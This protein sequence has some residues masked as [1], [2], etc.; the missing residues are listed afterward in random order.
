MPSSAQRR[1][2][3]RA[4]AGAKAQ[5][6]EED[7]SLASLAQQVGGGFS[8]FMRGANAGGRP[9][10]STQCRSAPHPRAQWQ[11][12]AH[13]TFRGTDGQHHTTITVQQPQT[14]NDSDHDHNHNETYRSTDALADDEA[15]DDDVFEDDD[16]D[17]ID[18][19][20]DGAADDAALRLRVAPE[21]ANAAGSSNDS[22]S[23]STYDNAD[24]VAAFRVTHGSYADA[25]PLQEDV[26]D[27]RAATD[28]CEPSG[29]AITSVY[30]KSNGDNGEVGRSAAANIEDHQDDM[31]ASD[32]SSG[33]TPAETNDNGSP[34]F[35]K[36]GDDSSACK[37]EALMDDGFFRASELAETVEEPEDI[38]DKCTTHEHFLSNDSAQA[39]RFETVSGLAEAMEVENIAAFSQ[40]AHYQADSS[41]SKD[42]LHGK[43]PA[44]SELD[45]LIHE[46]IHALSP[47]DK[48]EVL[49]ILE[50][51]QSEG[52]QLSKGHPLPTYEDERTLEGEKAHVSGGS[53]LKMEHEGPEN[54]QQP[55]MEQ[56]QSVGEERTLEYSHNKRSLPCDHLV[57]D[58]PLDSCAVA[59]HVNYSPEA[60][61][62]TFEH[63]EEH[64][65][66][67]A[68]SEQMDSTDFTFS[69]KPEEVV[70]D[71]Q[72]RYQEVIVRLVNAWSTSP[73]FSLR[74]LRLLDEDGNIIQL[75]PAALTVRGAP[76]SATK[77]AASLLSAP[78][79]NFHRNGRSTASNA[80]VFQT[81]QPPP[82][83]PP[84]ELLACV[85]PEL[86]Q[87]VCVAIANGESE[88]VGEEAK[89]VRQVHVYLDGALAWKG[90]LDANRPNIIPLRE[91]GKR[92]QL[93][94]DCLPLENESARSFSKGEGV[95]TAAEYELATHASSSGEAIVTEDKHNVPAAMDSLSSLKP[96]G[97]DDQHKPSMRILQPDALTQPEEE[98]DSATKERNEESEAKF[99]ESPRK[100]EPLQEGARHSDRTNVSNSR[101]RRRKRELEQNATEEE[102]LERSLDSL[103]FFSVTQA[104]RVGSL[105]ISQQFN[106][107][108]ATGEVQMNQNNEKTMP[109]HTE[110][111]SR[112]AGDSFFIP[113]QPNGQTLELLLHSTWGDEHYIGLAGIEVFDSAGDAICFEHE[114][115]AAP[116][117]INALPGHNEDPRTVDKLVDGICA[118]C[119]ELHHWLAP[120]APD[121]HPNRITLHLPTTLAL[122]MIRMF[123]YNESRIHAN[124]GARHVELRLD[125][126]TIFIGEIQQSNGRLEDAP[127]L[128]E[129]V[130]FT[131]KEE[132]FRALDR[133]DA[134]MYYTRNA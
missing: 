103:S 114:P 92:V 87:A 99:V 46:H 10:P 89:R 18:G 119:D 130:L 1:K 5:Q 95:S 83:A 56:I 79:G 88:S 72:P 115:E 40:K 35:A 19:A 70:D 64:A 39:E 51:W 27:E 53:S 42:E 6:R 80:P 85:P 108:A 13:L 54:T 25:S 128:A 33:P 31:F 57:R 28:V 76:A 133:F 84:V 47:D 26:A 30:S 9:E 121:G 2:W 45:A 62:S 98:E 74:A 69:T 12:P 11:R 112:T 124:R 125:G 102:L 126:S 93:P 7:S 3:L 68:N 41:E 34:W 60:N 32:N 132:T 48:R 91:E 104:G 38:D 50:Q 129:C 71:E 110:P 101:A 100:F 8:V 86:P 113:T 14:H 20:K 66:G 65:E 24:T 43:R 127:R 118:T 97:H 23:S 117:S 58:H 55:D 90:E 37:D 96:D 77:S 73:F 122:G 134:S 63:L 123:N 67:D 22:A 75:P 49:W 16:I 106:Q 78:L 116:S 105:S 29:Y 44:T 17:N 4:H 120:R 15:Y 36:P 111:S 131:E 21:D 109:L 52:K 107:P 61:A 94:S 59:D 81:P 82:G